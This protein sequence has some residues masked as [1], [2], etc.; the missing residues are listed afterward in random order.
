MLSDHNLDQLLAQATPPAPPSAA[1]LQ[2]IVAQA[3]VTP[4]RAP[5]FALGGPAGG[6]RLWTLGLGTPLLAAAAA[7][8][9]WD[10]QRFDVHR[11]VELPHR[12]AAALHRRHDQAGMSTHHDVRSVSAR[13]VPTAAKQS[14][15]VARS[16]S[17][18][19]LHPQTS[20][21]MPSS[22]SSPL[23][24][25]PA[26]PQR[27]PR[28][29]PPVP[30]RPLLPPVIAPHHYWRP[31]P[32]G[33]WDKGDE[34]RRRGWRPLAHQFDQGEHHDLFGA[35]RPLAPRPPAS[36][37]QWRG[38][39]GEGRV[40]GREQAFNRGCAL[41]PTCRPQVRFHPLPGRRFRPGSHRR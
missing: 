30:Q 6:R 27:K 14:S 19:G 21:T 8:A 7:A 26:T 1:L 4:Q 3:R 15:P 23:R 10:G 33:R 5:R 40:L 24:V 41:R 36:R 22:S 17:P 9:S 11:L 20:F 12:V 34:D 13:A 28:L 39:G 29:V 2:Q 32:Q 35:L 38:I 37:R 16:A 18:A 25:L 31:Q